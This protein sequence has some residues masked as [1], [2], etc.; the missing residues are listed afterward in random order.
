MKAPPR[1]HGSLK[2]V[3][4][5]VPDSNVISIH[6][7]RQEQL[8]A[9]ILANIEILARKLEHYRDMQARQ[10]LDEVSR[11]SNDAAIDWMQES[12]EDLAA[13]L[14]GLEMVVAL[15]ISGIA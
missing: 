6:R 3:P 7:I 4:A 13:T 12:I 9:D 1:P 5:F 8:V 11:M 2:A 10:C 14:T 15:P